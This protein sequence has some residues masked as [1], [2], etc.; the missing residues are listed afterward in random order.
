MGG[1]GSSV[2]ANDGVCV[3]EVNDANPIPKNNNDLRNCAF[4]V[5]PFRCSIGLWWSREDHRAR[6]FYIS[7]AKI[8]MRQ[9]VQTTTGRG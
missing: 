9:R 8:T 2:R 5:I 6:S 3:E 4:S 7:F 1:A